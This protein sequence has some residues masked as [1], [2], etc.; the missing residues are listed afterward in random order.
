LGH[1]GVPVGVVERNE[2]AVG[3]G[4]VVPDGREV[5]LAQQHALEPPALDLGHV[6]Q[7]TVE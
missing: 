2:L 3:D 1:V 7:Q 4:R 5:G 6:P